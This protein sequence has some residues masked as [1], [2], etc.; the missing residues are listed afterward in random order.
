MAEGSVPSTDELKLKLTPMQF[1][2]TQE[3]GT[4]R[5]FTGEYWDNFDPGT[6]LECAAAGSFGRA[7]GVDFSDRYAA[8]GVALTEE[9]KRAIQAAR[10][11]IEE[12][13]W[14]WFRQGK[15]ILYW[16]WSSDK[17]FIMN[18]KI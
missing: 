17:G 3:A 9:Q 7:H 16:H 1:H 6:F 18:K 13:D 14:D 15:K 8:E 4:E 5:P 12:V 10:A 11:P 2:V